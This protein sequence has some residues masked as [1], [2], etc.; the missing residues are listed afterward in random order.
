M[1]IDKLDCESLSNV[2]VTRNICGKTLIVSPCDQ[3]PFANGAVLDSS[4]ETG[5]GYFL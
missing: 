1:A 3:D 2:I 5:V 4:I